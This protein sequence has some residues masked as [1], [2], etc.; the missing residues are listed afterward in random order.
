M[1][2]TYKFVLSTWLDSSEPTDALQI[3]PVFHH[4]TISPDLGQMAN[5]LLDGWDTYLGAD[6]RGTQQRCTIY[7]VQGARPNYPKEQVQRFTDTVRAS[8]QNRDIAVCLSFYADDNR[9]RQRGRL[10]IPLCLTG[11]SPAGPNVSASIRTKIG[12]LV[13]LLEGLGGPD[14]D[15]GV[16]STVGLSFKKATHWWVDDAWD[17]QRRRGKRATARTLGTTSG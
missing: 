7:D 10:Y 8:T 3:T 13:P 16:W 15:W 1:P 6:V 14:W 5:D 12:A 9:P 17:T 11:M 2:A 4:K